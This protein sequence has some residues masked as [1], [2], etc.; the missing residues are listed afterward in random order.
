[1]YVVAT[2]SGYGSKPRPAVIV[3]SDLFTTTESV[4][5]CLMTAREIEAGYV[6]VAIAPTASN[7]LGRP[8][9]IMLDKVLAI[10]R[11][12][13]GPRVGALGIDDLRE[14]DRAMMLFFGLADPADA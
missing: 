10:H 12:K 2:G 3:Q 7:G 11:R 4:T 5:V 13:V 6:R 1:M 8:S 9:W 14:L